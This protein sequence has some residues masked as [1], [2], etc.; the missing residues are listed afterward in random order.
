VLEVTAHG[1]DRGDGASVIAVPGIEDVPDALAA[2]VF[3]I[4]A[5]LFALRASLALGR[6]PDNPFPDGEVNRVVRGVTVH[7]L[8]EEG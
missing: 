7:P 2:I 8:D 5:Q 4:V 3:V 1:G 6:T